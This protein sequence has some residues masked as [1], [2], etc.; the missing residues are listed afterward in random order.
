MVVV[1]VSAAAWMVSGLSAVVG[2]VS[3]YDEVDVDLTTWWPVA[4]RDRHWH[5]E[6]EFTIVGRIELRNVINCDCGVATAVFK[7]QTNVEVEAAYAY[8]A[9]F[10][11]AELV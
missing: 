6:E 11:Y 8:I 7:P 5:P 3:S 4:Q 9:I 1:C 10:A 2:D